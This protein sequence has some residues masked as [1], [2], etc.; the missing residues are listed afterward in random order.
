MF[1]A[2]AVSVLLIVFWSLD[3]LDVL[4]RTL[5]RRM[6]GVCGAVIVA[7]MVF[8]PKAFETAVDRYAREKAREFTE[9]MKAIFQELLPSSEHPNEHPTLP[10]EP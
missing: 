3:Y 6:S 5:A 7:A 1:F 4:P 2:I 9:Q 8:V 10:T